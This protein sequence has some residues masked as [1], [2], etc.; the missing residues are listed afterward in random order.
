MPPRPH[1]C[2][3]LAKKHFAKTTPKIA[4]SALSGDP[5]SVTSVTNHSILI[6]SP[7]VKILGLKRGF[8]HHKAASWPQ[9]HPESV[10]KTPR[11]NHIQN[12]TFYSV[13][14]S[15]SYYIDNQWLYIIHQI[16]LSK[17]IRVQEG[18]FTSQNGPRSQ[19]LPGFAKKAQKQPP[20]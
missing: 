11:Q 3:E 10:K 8:I 14:G 19:K 13:R 17:L 7:Q 6:E 20:K 4:R 2:P 16:N 18:F 5:T 12:S 9:I 1:S 15:D